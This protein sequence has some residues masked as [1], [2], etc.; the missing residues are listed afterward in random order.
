MAIKDVIKL[1]GQSKITIFLFIET[2][3]HELFIKESV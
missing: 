3:A 1:S 2:A